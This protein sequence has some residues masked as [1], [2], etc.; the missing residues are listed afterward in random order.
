MMY[1]QAAKP[2]PGQILAWSFY[3]AGLE[4][5][6]LLVEPLPVCGPDEIL[7]RIDA[8][9]LCA[10][11][12]KM[13]RMGGQYPLFFERDF[14]QTPA[15]LGHEVAL[16]IIQVGAAWQGN[17]RPGQ[18]LGLQPDVYLNGRR[19]IFGVNISGGMT[20]YL[21]LDRQVLAGD[22]G[23]YIFPVPP[24]LSYADV[25][26]L[27]PWA[28]VDVAYSPT[29]RRLE[30]RPD[31]VMWL[32]GRPGDKQA[33]QMNRPLLSARVILT[34]VPPELAAWV[35][36]Q[37]V[38]ALECA[39]ATTLPAELTGG[40]GVDDIVLLDPRR[41]DV[42]A[43]AVEYLAP[44]GCLNLVTARPLD[45]PVAIDMGRLHYEHLALLGCPGPD[46][47]QAYG[48]PRN[49]SEVRAGGVTWLVGAGGTMG[50]MN[51]Q[52]LLEMPNAPRAII[53]T[54]RG[55]ARLGSLKQD[56]GSLAEAN[57][58]ELVRISPA[59]EPGRLET[60]IDRLTAGR[61]CDDIVVVVPNIEAVESAL[62][63]LAADGMLVM[64]AGVPA[65]HKVD[66]PLDRVALHQAQF[67]GTSG[68][69]V[70]D[71]QRIIQKTQA[72][73]LSP[74][75]AVAAVGGM[76]AMKQGLQA[77]LEQ[78]YPGKVVIY[79]QLLDLPLLSLPELSAALPEV[80]ARLGPGPSWTAQAE[81][82]LFEQY[83]NISST[84]KG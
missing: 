3:G 80:S 38:E 2:L 64:F 43:A 13:V 6:Q 78:T 69:K 37:P 74:A 83:G 48:L 84:E 26:L 52:R 11:D 31:G 73:L 45:G 47:A 28:C 8:L 29:A 79:P 20:Q 35:R 23:S 49:R 39:V 16:T 42:V 77:V 33:Y 1:R 50:R 36:T 15:R 34:D 41:A 30:P 65:G 75:R 18:R 17:Y 44:Y 82:A 70:A 9:G 56:F 54:N 46:I 60:E 5:L 61:G 58:V 22:E 27:E 24:E 32:R 68:S 21:T 76:R 71:Q 51:L 4:N 81:Q 12:A 63:H 53:A 10:S 57:G 59:A 19:V 25:A 40:R 67:T 14:A 62:P 55:Q 7:V 66:L 72:G